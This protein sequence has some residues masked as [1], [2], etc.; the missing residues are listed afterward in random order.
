[1]SEAVLAQLA[2][3]ADGWPAELWGID[4]VLAV[5]AHPDDESFGL[6]A[7]IAR[8]VEHGIAVDLLCLTHGEASTVGDVADLRVVRAR[9]LIEAAEVLGIGQAWLEALPDGQLGEH[10]AQLVAL[11][12]GHLDGVGAL[13]VFDPS[14]VTGHRDHQIATEVAEEVADRRG[15]PS[16]EWGVASAVAAALSDEL[17]AGLVGLQG[18][19][20]V[21]LQVDRAR[22]RRA[23]SCHRS[24]DPGNPLLGRRLELQGDTER[25]RVR[26]APFDR[27]LSRFVA[28]AGELAQPDADFEART[29]LLDLLVGFAAGTTWPDGVFGVEL[30]RP[31]GVHCLH[32]D[33][34]GWTIATVVLAGNRATPPHDH[35][36]WGAAA[37]VTGIER[38]VRF[39]GVCPDGLRPLD[40]QLTPRGAGYLFDAGDIHQA[41]DVTGALTVSIHLLL[42]GGPEAHQCCREESTGGRRGAG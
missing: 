29:R 13:L 14:G 17:G 18:R 27:R 5:V 8:L 42:R 24:Q 36:S 10:R 30:T 16:L 9:E 37:T 41:S 39:A 20:V 21:E 3:R 40:A 2:V 28:A 22:Q 26:S 1:M 19:D 25:V 11:I 34:D 23:I 6:G 33:P 4:R 32:D 15:I 7:L 31:Y 12:E 35:E 38:N